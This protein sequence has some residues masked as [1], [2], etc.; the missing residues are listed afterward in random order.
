MNENKTNLLK[1]GFLFLYFIKLTSQNS[2][3][4]FFFFNPIVKEKKVINKYYFSY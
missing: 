3:F 2:F 4:S 1:L